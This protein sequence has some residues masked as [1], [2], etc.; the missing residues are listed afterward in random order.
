M[1]EIIHEFGQCR[2]REL[3]CQSPQEVF[4]AEK[5]VSSEVRKLVAYPLG[6]EVFH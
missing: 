4:R 6:G 2:G 5:A 3:T 1:L